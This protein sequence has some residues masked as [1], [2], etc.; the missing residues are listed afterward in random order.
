MNITID[1][2]EYGKWR[3]LSINEINE[4]RENVK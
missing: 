3:Y 1:G 2:I 4:L